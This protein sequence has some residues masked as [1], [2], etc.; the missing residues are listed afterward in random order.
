MGWRS[1]R[2]ATLAAVLAVHAL[3]LIALLLWRGDIRMTSPGPP[4]EISF[5]PRNANPE[6][7]VPPPLPSAPA[8]SKPK[9]DEPTI[10][11]LPRQTGESELPS[12]DWTAE[13]GR[14]AEAAA[15]RA[16]AAG[17]TPSDSPSSGGANWFQPPKY[18]AGDE[19]GLS[20][21]DTAVF[22]NERCYQIAPRIPPIVD[23]SH[24][25]MGLHTYCKGG[26]KDPNG[27]LFKDTA[28]YKKL[29]PQQ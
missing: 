17:P 3:L 21:G 14:A 11:L 1:S 7:F 20:N 9:I 23:A 2:Y 8:R 18:K 22:I 10:I 26:P 16:A 6:K 25:G 19:V 5:V 12:V 4:L 15:K 29:H 13:A 27:D 28:A 24:N